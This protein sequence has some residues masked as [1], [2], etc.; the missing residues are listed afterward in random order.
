MKKVPNRRYNKKSRVDPEE[1]R[2]V[3]N[4]F[5]LRRKVRGVMQTEYKAE[6]PAGW[7]ERFGEYPAW[8]EAVNNARRGDKVTCPVCGKDAMDVEYYCGLCETCWCEVLWYCMTVVQ[9]YFDE[10][11]A[12]LF[13]AEHTDQLMIAVGMIDKA[14]EEH[15]LKELVKIAK[16]QK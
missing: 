15:R 16:R 10:H 13:S 1:S 14:K 5:R 6:Y 8:Q 3:A 4:A 11:P 2:R 12:E 9:R 7:L